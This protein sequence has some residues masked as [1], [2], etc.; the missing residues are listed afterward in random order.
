MWI[1]VQRGIVVLC[2]TN[3]DRVPVGQFHACSNRNDIIMFGVILL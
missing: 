3:W 2:G 1:H